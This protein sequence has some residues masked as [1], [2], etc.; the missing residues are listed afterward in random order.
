MNINTEEALSKAEILLKDA[1]K[2]VKPSI[3]KAKI[4]NFH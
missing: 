2:N 4:Y 3:T 1:I